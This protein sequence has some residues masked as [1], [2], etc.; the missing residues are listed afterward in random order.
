M[1]LRVRRVTWE[2]AM[3]KDRFDLRDAQLDSL[4]FTGGVDLGVGTYWTELDP[5]VVDYA[6]VS[7]GC[8]MRRSLILP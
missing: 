7:V 6:V 4:R 2:S 3:L 8:R 5:A 1:N